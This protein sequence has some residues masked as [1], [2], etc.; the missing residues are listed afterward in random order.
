MFLAGAAK[1]EGTAAGRSSLLPYLKVC[2]FHPRLQEGY[3]ESFLRGEGDSEFD[4]E[5][6][7]HLGLPTILRGQEDAAGSDWSSAA[8]RAAALR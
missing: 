2:H 7:Y 3:Y 5:L 4:A 8:R 1:A 6:S